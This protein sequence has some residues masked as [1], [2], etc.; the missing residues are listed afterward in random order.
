MDTEELKKLIEFMNENN[1]AEL[2]IEE[3]GRKVRLVKVGSGARE[4]V[5]MPAQV[6]AGPAQSAAAQAAGGAPAA[7][8]PPANIHIIK[9]PMVGTFYRAPSP[10][11]DPFAD[12]GAQVSDDTTV[13]I[14][15]AMKVMNEIRAEVTGTIVEVLAENGHPVE[16]GQPLFKVQLAE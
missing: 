4:V 7:P 2:E 14:I 10:D 11:S 3:E 16:Y 6:P 13:C 1:L 15:E 8:E 5:A 9:A 12:A